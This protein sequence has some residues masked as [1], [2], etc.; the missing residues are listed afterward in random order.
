MDG[1]A[2]T[3][4]E[5]SLYEADEHAWM[6]E[7]L[8]LVREGR[9]GEL[10]RAH[11]EEYFDGMTRRDRRAIESRLVRLLQHMLKF[12]RQPWR[13]TRSWRLTV[14]EQQSR[15]RWELKATPSL[16]PFASATLADAY[17]D[18]RRLASEETGLRLGAFPEE[19]PYT[20]DEA[21][22]WE[23]PMPGDPPRRRT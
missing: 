19:C 5:R 17:A 10:D 3:T 11:L 22:A 15:L 9:L 6:L 23:P 21:L 4:R 13:A 8:A 14:L 1:S 18:A 7:Q 2:G 20:L 12:D 16:R